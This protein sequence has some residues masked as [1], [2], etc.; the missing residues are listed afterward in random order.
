MLYSTSPTILCAGELLMDLISTEYAE[1]FRAADRY[2][3]LPGGSPANLAMNLAR[4]GQSV[5]L[6]A[7]VGN[8]D[9]G[10]LLIDAL[11]D[12]GVD[13]SRIR[14]VADPTTLILVT[15]SQAVSNFEPY[16]LADRRI[17]SDQFN[18]LD[19]S[20]LKLLHTTA[21]ALSKEPARTAILDAFERGAAAGAKRPGPRLSIDFNYADKIWN[22]DRKAGRATLKWFAEKGALIKISDVDFNRVFG[23]DVDDPA[24]AARR[25]YEAGAELVCLTLGDKGCYVVSRKEEFHLSA[26]TLEVVDTTGAGD[27]FWSGFLAAYVEGYGYRDCALAGR[28]TA[29]R[30]LTRL[31]PIVDD[32]S[33]NELLKS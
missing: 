2:Q 23:S 14:Q 4:L 8:D 29:E 24:E 15:K 10:G 18:G 32:L 16:R 26:R 19:W 31:G 12:A 28:A 20:S 6:V 27:A 25:I 30:Q 9:A 5:T 17:A 22:K 33:V 13:V 3:R 1:N 7:A 11:R 21:F